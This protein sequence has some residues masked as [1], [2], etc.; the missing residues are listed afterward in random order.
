MKTSLL[1]KKLLTLIGLFALLIPVIWYTNKTREQNAT[2][3]F[4]TF[5]LNLKGKVLSVNVPDRFHGCGIIDLKILSTNIKYYDPR[6]ELDGYLC[7]IKDSIAQIYQQGA[8]SC[9]PGDIVEINTKDKKISVIRESRGNISS[10]IRLYP[11]RSFYKYVEKRHQ[12]F[13]NKD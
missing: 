4:S 5:D 12:S 10:T 3:Y 7:L 1:L 6:K 11:H 8:R 2:K 9:S 13:F